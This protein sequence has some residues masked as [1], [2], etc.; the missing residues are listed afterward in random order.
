MTNEHTGQVRMSD[1]TQ[2]HEFDYQ[3]PAVVWL[4]LKKHR[5]LRVFRTRNGWHLLGDRFRVP[6]QEWLDRIGSGW[7][8]DDIHEGRVV[9]MGG[10]WVRGRNELLQLDIET[11]HFT[12]KP[13]EVGCRCGVVRA[14]LE[15]LG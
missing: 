2:A 5:M 10:R 4:C 12:G 13:F 15:G 8:A 9:A 3:P 1:K 14:N 11:W 6:M 7:T